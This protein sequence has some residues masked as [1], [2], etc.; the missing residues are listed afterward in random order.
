MNVNKHEKIV[1]LS[2]LLVLIHYSVLIHP[3]MANV[4]G[5]SQLLSIYS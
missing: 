3:S 1:T 2:E 4:T 5:A